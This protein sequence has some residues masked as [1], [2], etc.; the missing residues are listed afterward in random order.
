MREKDR[1]TELARLTNELT[2]S[3]TRWDFLSY[4]GG[5]DPFWPD[6][7]NL[8]LVRNHIMYEKRAIQELLETAEEELSFF[9]V[10]YP[11]IYFR[12]TP[13][14]MFPHYMVKA[15]EIRQ[16]AAEQYAL[17]IQNPNFR[18]ILNNH[19]KVFPNGETRAT[20]AAGLSIWSTAGLS[21]Y[22]R[23]IDSGDLVAMRRNF[24]EP[25]E[26]KAIRWAE[27]AK[28]LKAFQEME[29]RPEDNVPVSDMED[30]EADC[31]EE[32]ENTFTLPVQEPSRKASLD[33]Q[34]Q[35]AKAKKPTAEK[36]IAPREEQL[37]LF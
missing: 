10:A 22:R 23:C 8:N 33:D 5:S 28:A 34:I 17:Y 16:R 35:A 30:W 1:D 25:Y 24:Y 4:N 32:F 13:P 19:E 14:E 2:A 37:S 20:K 12:E 3:F 11:D 9:G 15:D 18:Y 21:R 27:A 26:K 31:S 29:H 36:V 6:G 7:A